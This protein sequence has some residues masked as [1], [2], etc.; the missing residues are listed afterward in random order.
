[1]ASADDRTCL[2]GDKLP[3]SPSYQFHW[4]SIREL[5]SPINELRS[6]RGPVAVMNND[7]TAHDKTGQRDPFSP[8]NSASDDELLALTHELYARGVPLEEP[9]YQHTPLINRQSI[10]QNIRWER[11]E[12]LD[13]EIADALGE[14]VFQFHY[15]NLSDLILCG[16][17]LEHGPTI[18]V[19]RVGARLASAHMSYVDIWGRYL[20]TLAV[21]PNVDPY[22]K[23]HLRSLFGTSDTA[24]ILVGLGVMSSITTEIVLDHTG[25]SSD[26]LYNEIAGWIRQSKREDR[27]IIEEYLSQAFSKIPE[28]ERERWLGKN[29]AAYRRFAQ[30][31]INNNNEAAAALDVPL[32]PLHNELDDAIDTFYDTIGIEEDP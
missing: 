16:R 10:A 23:E 19:K 30:R 28:E 21:H 14:I 8:E 6:V 27:T 31:L 26:P 29:A 9:E 5:D 2:A 12:E 18:G 20:N 4:F 24:N 25:Q 22:L 7:D 15:G 13:P 32:R 11:K 17:L 3:G 1:M